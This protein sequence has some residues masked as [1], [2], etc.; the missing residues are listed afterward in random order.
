[1]TEWG[2]VCL[3]L[4][5]DAGCDVYVTDVHFGRRYELIA[6]LSTLKPSEHRERAASTLF[7]THS[8]R[9]RRAEIRYKLL[10][11]GEYRIYICVNISV[12]QL[13]TDNCGYCNTECRERILEVSICSSSSKYIAHY[14][15]SVAMHLASGS[16]T[17]DRSTCPV[18]SHRSG[19][20]CFKNA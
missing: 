7:R 4:V 5:C 14:C 2:T 18:C 6:R 9:T 8:A 16:M 15:D 20:E 13:I 3:W 17:T 12:R 1:M 11:P 19:M 10:A